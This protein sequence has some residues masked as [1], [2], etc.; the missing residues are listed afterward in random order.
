MSNTVKRHMMVIV[1]GVAAGLSLAGGCKRAEEA[2]GSGDSRAEVMVVVTD[3]GPMVQVPAGTF[4]MGSTAGEEHE[5]PV[6]EVALQAFLIDQYEVTQA[7]FLKLMGKDPSHFK[8]ADQ[9]VEQISWADAAL[10]CNARS[11]DDGLEPCYDEETGVCNFEANGYRLP[12]EAEWEYACRAGSKGAYSFGDNPGQLSSYGWYEDNAN[13]QPQKVGQLKPNAWGLYDMHGNVME[14]CN[15]VY[16][17]D[18]YAT[19][20][21]ED[22]QGPPESAKSRFVLRGGAWNRP[23]ADCR[24]SWRMGEYPG[25]LDGCFGRDDLGFRCVRKAPVTASE[26]SP[27]GY[28]AMTAVVKEIATQ[29]GQRRIVSLLEGGY[30]LAGL[31]SSAAA[32]VGA[33]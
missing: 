31:A 25:Q 32:H 7:N 5:R 23:A 24:S 30:D 20:P 13:G 12:T 2:G 9:P 11:K 17:A 10:Y 3:Y 18:Y 28:A 1:V 22:P 6:H 16:A 4:R 19:S 27:A 15:D 33:L 21:T 8:G 26:E 14:W 29:A